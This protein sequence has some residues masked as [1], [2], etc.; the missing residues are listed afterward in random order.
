MKFNRKN[1]YLVI[2]DVLM[3]RWS[4]VLRSGDGAGISWQKRRRQ[5]ENGGS[6]GQESGVHR[7]L[8]ALSTLSRLGSVWS[9]LDLNE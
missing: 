5:R 4:S 6:G 9:L 8:H 7:R 3:A 2:S 1:T